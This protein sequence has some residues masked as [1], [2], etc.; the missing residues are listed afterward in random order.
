MAAF[1]TPIRL[2]VPLSSN[3][4]HVCKQRPVC[5]VGEP[6]RVVGPPPSKPTP[7]SGPHESKYYRVIQPDEDPS[8]LPPTPPV[9]YSVPYVGYLLEDV[10]GLSS[11]ASRAKKYGALYRSSFFFG[12]FVYLT[13]M[14]PMNDMLRDTAVFSSNID[15]FKFS[16]FVGKD[17]LLFMDG[18]AHLAERNKIAPAFSPSMFPLY[19]DGIRDLSERTWARLSRRADGKPFKLDPELRRFYAAITIELTTGVCGDSDLC[20]RVRKSFVSM[21]DGLIGPAFG[22]LWDRTVRCR[23]EIVSILTKVVNEKLEHEADTIERLRA[24][25]HDQSSLRSVKSLLKDGADILQVLLAASQ[26]KTGPNHTHDPDEFRKLINL[27]LLLWL[28]GFFTTAATTSCAMFEMGKD[29]EIMRRLVV[30][31]DDIV[32]RAGSARV[33]FDQLEQMPLLDSY[34]KEIMRLFPAG[35][36]IMRNVEKDVV[37]M[38]KRIPKG[39]NVFCD[40]QAANRDEAVFHDAEKLIMD[41]FVVK[42]DGSDPPP[43]IIAFGGQASPHFCIGSA[44]AKMM[45]RT[46]LAVFLRGYE[47]ELDPRQSK[48]YRQIPD[49]TPA[50]EI[51]VSSL[52]RRT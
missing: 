33:T 12:D 17:S 30:E 47:L 5:V 50:S 37:L 51:L 23:N 40:L 44:L 38:G 4:K 1:A 26:F 2:N 24:S 8:T 48:R 35:N 34:L 25:L 39:T 16:F 20:E 42:H 41:R 3:S 10:L 28:A 52:K 19:F 21:I 29:P 46:N 43:R 9:H 49:Y 11:P 27:L 7:P 32:R 45:L 13:S 22:P 18:P 36:G 6:Q 31:Q 14:A 15:L